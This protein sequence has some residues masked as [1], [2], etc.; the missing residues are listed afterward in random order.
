MGVGSDG[1]ALSTA[2]WSDVVRAEGGGSGRGTGEGIEGTCNS[3]RIY[4]LDG[5]PLARL[6]VSYSRALTVEETA[7]GKRGVHLVGVQG[8]VWKTRRTGEKRGEWVKLNPR[9]D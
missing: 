8:R 2:S 4:L 5:V 9:Q 3:S 7:F 1:L 6:T